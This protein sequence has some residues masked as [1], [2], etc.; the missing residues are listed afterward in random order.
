MIDK[1]QLKKLVTT[2]IIIFVLSCNN[3]NLHVEKST[4]K[5]DTEIALEKVRAHGLSTEDY[6]IIGDDLIIEGDISFKINDLLSDTSRQYSHTTIIGQTNSHNIRIKMD[7]NMTSIWG[8]ALDE[9]IRVFNSVPN[10]KL[11]ISRVS[12]SSTADIRIFYADIGKFLGYADF[13]SGDG[14]PGY[15]LRINDYC[16]DMTYWSKL[17]LLSH[18]LGHNIGLRHQNRIE[19]GLVY[20][21]GTPTTHKDPDSIMNQGI[22]KKMPSWK[23]LSAN[24]KKAISFLYPAT[25]YRTL[26]YNRSVNQGFPHIEL[27]KGDVN[28]DGRADIIHAWNNNGRMA[29]ITY[30]SNG[31][32][33]REAWSS[34]NMGEGAPTL[35]LLTGD[36]N[37]DGKT[38]IIQPWSNNGTMAILTYLSN[39]RG[40]YR[41]WGSAN[42]GEGAPTLGLLT[43]DVNGDGKTDIIQPWNNNGRMALIVYRS[44]G[45]GYYTSW[46]SSNMKQGSGTLGLLTAD[47]NGDGKT[48]IIQPWNNNG[49]LA[50]IVYKSDGRGYYNSWGSSNMNNGCDT[51][52]LKVADI[53]GDGKDDLIQPWN[54]GGKMAIISYLS[55]GHSYSEAWTNGN[56]GLSSS[57]LHIFVGDANGD[58]K[59]DIIQPCLTYGKLSAVTY[60]SNGKGFSLYGRDNLYQNVYNYHTTSE[61]MVGDVNRDGKMDIIQPWSN[62]GTLAFAIFNAN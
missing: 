31:V 13:P 3:E 49:R 16:N 8:A 14:K 39:G 4:P 41:A 11:K 54:N 51:L 32:I 28:G 15:R 26:W 43:G 1:I 40:Y 45:K 59:D 61:M 33:F 35:G 50:L 29:M 47:V 5:S 44:N 21:P 57:N 46:G 7:D 22:F 62:N 34:G 9:V 12:S 18:E 42:M 53:N 2:I 10:S 17:H 25:V 27:L 60:K 36:V 56:M 58:G 55:N 38:D 48:D 23:S 24:D 6:E 52:G 37:G 19:D 30:L 20:I